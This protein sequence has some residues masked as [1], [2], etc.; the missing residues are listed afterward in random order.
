M[1]LQE[2]PGDR[3]DNQRHRRGGGGEQHRVDQGR[4]I[5]RLGENGEITGKSSRAVCAGDDEPRHR[6]QEKS[7]R[8]HRKR[9]Q[10]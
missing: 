3:C 7:R 8:H 2:H 4:A 1:P 6:Q 9:Q 10:A 5:T